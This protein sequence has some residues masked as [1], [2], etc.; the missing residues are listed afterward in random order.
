M[1]SIYTLLLVAILLSLTAC[2]TLKKE[3][4]ELKDPATWEEMLQA[5]L[6]GASLGAG[7]TYTTTPS[8]SSPTYSGTI[9][10]SI[11]SQIDGDFEGWDGDTIVI[12]INGQI[13]KQDDYH[14]EYCYAFMPRV[15]VY[16]SGYGYKMMVKGA[17][18]AVR[19]TQLR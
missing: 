14:Y 12:L 6:L 7:N 17:R 4:A 18:K 15:V 9:S 1:K 19:V 13:W 3:L 2:S 16:R 11:E 8:Y 10:S 5:F